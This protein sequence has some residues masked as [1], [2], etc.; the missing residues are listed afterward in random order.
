MHSGENFEVSRD[1]ISINAPGIGFF[2]AS[3]GDN[4]EYLPEEGADPDWVSLCLN[5]QVLA[6]ILHQ[7]R[8]INFHSS[9]LIY[10]NRGIMILGETGSGKSSLTTA[11]ALDGAE[12]LSDDFTAVTFK[13]R[14]PV[15]WPFFRP[16]KIREETAIQLGIDRRRLRKAEKGTGKF[17]IDLP[18]SMVVEFPLN[19][20][21]KIEVGDCSD[22]QLFIPEISEQ[23]IILRSEICS[24]EMLAGMPETEREYF[25]QLISI[26]N[27]VWIVRVI[28]PFEIGIR[29]L[30]S[31][32]SKFISEKP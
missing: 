1:E 7:R 28:R 24:W 31:A 20:I 13:D 30:Y 19:L 17:F 26:L 14:K 8:V 16:V 11:F 25:G 22:T 4:I 23:F 3:N 10:K 32:V 29:E 15:I 2:Y 27:S 5:S 18:E 6:A 12:F 9:S 21:L